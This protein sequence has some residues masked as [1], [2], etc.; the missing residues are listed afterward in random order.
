MGDR[1]KQNGVYH[2]FWSPFNDDNQI[3]WQEL[4]PFCLP[5]NNGS[6]IWWQPIDHHLIGLKEFKRS[7]EI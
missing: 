6:Q 5:S 1:N 2:I 7:E 4:N 3:F